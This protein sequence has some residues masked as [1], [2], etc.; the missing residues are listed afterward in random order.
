M[1]QTKVNSSFQMPISVAL[2]VTFHHL[3]LS[4]DQYLVKLMLG[5]EL[6]SVLESTNTSKEKTDLFF[7]TVENTLIKPWFL[8]QDL[9]IV[10]PILKVFQK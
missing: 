6:M 9:I 5:L 1:Y 4:L 2:T 7:L 3:S 8:L 10:I